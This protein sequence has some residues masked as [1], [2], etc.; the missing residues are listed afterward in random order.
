MCA[1]CS[2]GK[3]LLVCRRALAMD[4]AALLV[5]LLLDRLA[6][7]AG[8]AVGCCGFFHAL[9]FGLPCLH[10][11]DF[12]LTGACRFALFM[13]ACWLPGADRC[14][15]WRSGRSRQRR[16]RGRLPASEVRSV[17]FMVCLQLSGDDFESVCGAQSGV[18]HMTSQRDAAVIVHAGG[19]FYIWLRLV[20]SVVRR[21]CIRSGHGIHS[22]IAPSEYNRGEHAEAS[23][24]LTG[25]DVAA[26]DSH[27]AA[28]ADGAKVLRAM[29]V[30]GRWEAIGDARTFA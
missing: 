26:A 30:E 13:R 21:R 20:Q 28:I 14:W 29:A 17:V 16:R 1:F 3:L 25:R 4:P 27:K 7:G 12:A 19:G 18:R 23:T 6:L 22:G 9:Y 10:A 11:S 8:P 24:V 5:L 15:G 2:E